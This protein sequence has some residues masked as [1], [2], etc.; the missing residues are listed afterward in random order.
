MPRRSKPQKNKKV[1]KFEQRLV[2]NVA[3]L[4]SAPNPYGQSRRCTMMYSFAGYDGTTTP[5]FVTSTLRLGDLKD[6]DGAG[7]N[8]L[9]YDTMIDVFNRY[10]VLGAKVELTICPRNVG[11]ERMAMYPCY[12]DYQPTT[13]R[14]AVE[15]PRAVSGVAN[16]HTFQ[17]IT[18]KIDMEEFV[19]PSYKD[20]DWSG[21]DSSSP[22]KVVLYRLASA[23]IVAGTTYIAWFGRVYLDVLWTEP[24]VPHDA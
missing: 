7:S 5:G 10:K 17:T 11:P 3:K 14:Q 6:M 24:V 15:R 13:M 9:G 19:G 1:A 8:P 20:L 18:S 2:T 16:M 22:S 12:P 23:P 21:T 4:S